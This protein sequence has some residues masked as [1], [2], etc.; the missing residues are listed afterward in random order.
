MNMKNIVVS[1]ADLAEKGD[2]VTPEVRKK[3][4]QV[5]TV[6]YGLG[7]AVCSALDARFAAI[8][9]ESWLHSK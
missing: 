6:R 9:K 3:Q 1:A 7:S 4:N 2:V 8:Q 5:R